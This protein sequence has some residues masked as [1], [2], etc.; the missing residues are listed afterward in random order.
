MAKLPCLRDIQLELQGFSS[1]SH[2]TYCTCLETVASGENGEGHNG[3]HEVLLSLAQCVHQSNLN[4]KNKR[5][6]Y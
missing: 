6:I 1:I 5:K 2:K 3:L 4:S